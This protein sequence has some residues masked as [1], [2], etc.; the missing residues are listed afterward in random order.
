MKDT[1]AVWFKEKLCVGG[2]TAETQT[3]SAKLYIYS[4]DN[5]EWSLTSTPVTD[6]ALA[7][8]QSRIVLAGGKEC[9]CENS[10]RITN[11]VW[12]MADEQI[13]SWKTD[14]IPHMKLQRSGAVATGID[15]VLIVAGGEHESSVLYIEIYDESMW[16][17]IK[18]PSDLVGNDVKMA[19][20]D[21][22]CYLMGG[23]H[24]R[25]VFSASLVS[26]IRGSKVGDDH[27]DNLSVWR[28]IPD[29]P[30]QVASGCPA[31]FGSRLVIQNGGILCAFCPGTEVWVFVL[32]TLNE[33]IYFASVIGSNSELMVIGGVSADTNVFSKQ[34]IQVSLNCECTYYNTVQPQLSGP[35]GSQAERY[36]IPDK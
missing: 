6:F 16:W 21:G 27:E 9:F 8:Y 12:V 3:D 23:R 2:G 36:T 15:S 25:S 29:V 5:S 33:D 17:N 32:N 35:L 10:S 19:L 30:E 26:L 22:D 34:I 28:Q 20:H 14:I 24:G 1:Q 18:Q 31:V 11:K 7:V 13:S 4:M